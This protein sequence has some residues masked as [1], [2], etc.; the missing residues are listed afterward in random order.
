MLVLSMKV[1]VLWWGPVG[2]IYRC[3]SQP[4]VL[5]LGEENVSDQ[6]VSPVS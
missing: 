5:A 2:G 6:E 3:F 1:W 4:H